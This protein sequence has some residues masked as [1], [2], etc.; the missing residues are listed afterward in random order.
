MK[1]IITILTAAL[2]VVVLFTACG[3][4]EVDLKALMEDINT[5]YELTGLTN[6]EDADAL[7]RYYQ[8]DAEN[9]KQFAAEFSKEAGNYNEIILIEAA[10]AAAAESITKQLE[11]RLRNQ[12]SDAKSYNAEQVSMIEGCEVKENGNY[13]YLVI[14][15]KQNEIN[16]DIEAAL[17]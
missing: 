15:D 16:A 12:L 4:K 9:V 8:T 2:L 6:V 5:K 11:L 3:A 1:R 17:K 10:D 14:G 7:H 13:V